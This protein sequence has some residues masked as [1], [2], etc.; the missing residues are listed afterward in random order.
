MRLDKYLSNAGTGSRKDVKAD[1]KK[2]RVTV[3]GIVVKDPKYAVEGSEEIAL[4]HQ[5]VILEQ[6]IYIMLNKPKDVISSTEKGSARTVIDLI[7]HPQSSSLF[8]VGRL[9]KDTTGLL[10][11]TDDGQLAHELLSPSNRIGKTYIAQLRDNVSD[12]DISMLEAGIPLKD[13]TTA[14]A[15]AVR[16]SEREVKL[17]ITEGKYHQVKRMF[18]Y[19]GNEVVGLERIGFATLTLDDTL[20]QGDYRRLTDDE[21]DMLKN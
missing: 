18:R 8:P 17:T 15:S 16:M 1:I 13:F 4:N 9:D 21:I 2:G 5:P 12:S 19:L 20:K 11:I 7:D 14:P 6:G 3:G 10:F